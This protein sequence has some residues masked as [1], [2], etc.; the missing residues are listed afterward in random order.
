MKVVAAAAVALVVGFL[1]GGIGPRRELQASRHTVTSLQEELEAARKR[2]GRGAARY[3][4]FPAFDDVPRTV[5]AATPARTPV[6]E[7][8]EPAVSPTRTPPSAMEAFE[9]ALA[10]QRMRA[11][12]SR[13]ALAEKARLSEREI[14]EIDAIVDRM[15]EA[16]A[17]HSKEI[18]AVIGTGEE[19]DALTVIDVSHDVTGILYE[20][21]KSFEDVVGSD[22]PLVD[23]SARQVWNYVD[24]EIFRDAAA[25][26]GFGVVP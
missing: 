6:A 1:L 4:P 17:E 15:N 19:P 5:P 7:G 25:S 21:Q 9:T 11:R 18:L 23:E 24:L 26:G 8:G 13:Q 14:E 20:S 22:L 2:A 12:Q 10:A 3:L 16:L